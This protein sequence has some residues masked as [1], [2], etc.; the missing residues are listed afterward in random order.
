MTDTADSLISLRE[1]PY[2]FRTNLKVRSSRRART[3]HI[4]QHPSHN[5]SR[6]NNDMGTNVIYIPRSW[7]VPHTRKTARV[8][9][10]NVWCVRSDELELCAHPSAL[11]YPYRC[12]ICLCETPVTRQIA[13]M[14]SSFFHIRAYISWS[15]PVWIVLM[16]NWNF[17]RHLL[18]IEISFVGVVEIKQWIVLVHLRPNLSAVHMLRR[19][20]VLLIAIRPSDEDVKPVGS[21]S[22]FERSR[23]LVTGFYH[24]HHHPSY[25]THTTKQLNIVT[26]KS[27]HKYGYTPST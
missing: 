11:S 20:I 4:T 22:A 3:S 14:C 21:L 17:H 25:N 6:E 26:P 9:L 8:S 12:S 5:E 7:L 10:C 15:I 19:L 16:T 23:I 2:E 18:Y 24:H 27:V 1:K 13:I